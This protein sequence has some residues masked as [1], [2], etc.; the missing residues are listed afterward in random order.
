MNRVKNCTWVKVVLIVAVSLAIL[1]NIP[2]AAKS[3]QMVDSSKII[4]L[5]F[6]IGASGKFDYLRDGLKNMLAGRLAVG[7]GI[8]ELDYSSYER[9]L[10]KLKSSSDRMEVEGLLQRLK[11]DYLVTGTLY[12][13]HESLR[14]ELVFYPASHEKKVVRFTASAP[15][16]E[17]VIGALDDISLNITE[18]VFGIKKESVAS[19]ESEKGRGGLSGFE[20]AHPEKI[21]KKGIYSALSL[22]GDTGL[23][24]SKNVKRSPLISMKIVAMDVAD[25]NGDG[26]EEIVV[27]SRDQIRIFHYEAENFDEVGRIPLPGYLKVHGL[28]LADLDN[29]GLKEMVVSASNN[30]SAASSIIQWHSGNSFSYKV[31]DAP[32]YIRPVDMVDGRGIKLVGQKAVVDISDQQKIVEPGLYY[33][34]QRQDGLEIGARLPV[35]N[36]VNLFDFLY[37]DLD[38]DKVAELVVV[39]DREKL[40]VYSHDNKLL[41]VS[42]DQYGGSLNYFGPPLIKDKDGIDRALTYIPARIITVDI[43]NDSNPEILIS[44]NR[45]STLS[46]YSLLPNSRDYD[47]GSISCLS[48]NGKSMTELWRTN[49]LP[50]YIS[51]YQ[52]QLGV[53]EKSEA[54]TTATLWIAQVQES[55]L[56]DLFSSKSTGNHIH[57]YELELSAKRAA[58]K[59]ESP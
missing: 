42:E 3:K 38:G 25:I 1:S 14:L 17:K 18:K 32:Y 48:W 35:P 43:D 15:D 10:R 21:F 44:R 47:N 59:S 7:A 22:Q 58:N 11:I 46:S 2:A 49:L 40:L 41:W 23:I 37:V 30:Y 54:G 5:P 51:D 19:A 4:I 9:E 8:A 24:T 52:F 29:N 36:S 13:L 27:A 31:K 6:E 53:D 20:T 33:L 50:G 26:K 12:S 45:L 34:N 16:A 55:G 57:E 56:L 28:N 39:D